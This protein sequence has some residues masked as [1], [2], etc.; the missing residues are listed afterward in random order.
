MRYPATAPIS[1]T[2]CASFATALRTWRQKHKIPMKKVAR[3]LDLSV[4]TIDSWELGKRFPTGYNFERLVDYTSLPPCRLFC[5]M[6]DKCVPTDWRLAL[7][8]KS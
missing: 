4:A 5:V 3:D 7:G 1:N 2:P 8:K 6:A